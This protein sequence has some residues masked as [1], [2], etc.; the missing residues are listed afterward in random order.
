MTENERLPTS[1][2]WSKKNSSVTLQDI[3][4][5]VD[6]IRNATNLLT[7]DAEKTELKKRDV[8]RVAGDLH[9]GLGDL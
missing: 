1:L 7:G 6:H 5:A 8:R 2:G 4:T 3:L 9:F